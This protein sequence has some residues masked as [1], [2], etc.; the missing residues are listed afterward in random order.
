VTAPAVPSFQQLAEIFAGL[1]P[2]LRASA[3]PGDALRYI[4]HHAIEVIPAAEAAAVTIGQKNNFETIAATSDLPMKVDRIQYEL[5]SGPCVD[6]VKQQTVFKVADLGT[7]PR[8]PE[9]GP[10]ALDET[11]VQSMLSFRMYLE[12]SPGMLAGLNMY[13]KKPDAFG[14]EDEFLGLLLSTHGALAVTTMQH[15]EATGHLR[16][17]L[18]SNRRIGAA[19]GIL[20]ANHKIT[21]DQGFDLLRI[22]SQHSHRKL[23]DLAND[24]VETGHLELPPK[25][26]PRGRP[27]L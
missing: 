17:A 6:A 11:G 19:V 12:D 2:H 23:R 4:S 9:F 18:A 3:G 27:A 24:V 21:E 22:A 20:M 5:D 15:A 1:E 8:W 13:S 26:T 25:L 10:R 16:T 7:D 14:S